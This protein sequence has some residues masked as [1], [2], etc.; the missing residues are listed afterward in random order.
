MTRHNQHGHKVKR[1]HWADG[2]LK[3][4]DFYFETLKLAQVFA[5]NSRGYTVKIYNAFGELVYQ[6]NIDGSVESYA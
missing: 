2:V 5:Q 6:S 4:E 3:T 1:H